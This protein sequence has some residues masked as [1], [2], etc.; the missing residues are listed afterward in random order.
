[1][2]Q[3]K[4]Q[5]ITELYQVCYGNANFHD[6]GHDLAYTTQAILADMKCELNPVGDFVRLLKEKL[7]NHMV[8]KHIHVEP[9][10]ICINCES[11]V[12]WD[13]ASFCPPLNGWLGHNCCVDAGENDGYYE[14][15]VL[16]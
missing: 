7:P 8:W 2:S 9:T 15:V 6:I 14:E 5:A 16:T 3:N 13:Q 10:V 11:E 4:L 1:M 12:L